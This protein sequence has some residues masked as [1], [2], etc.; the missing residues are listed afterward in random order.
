MT[1]DERKSVLECW[2]NSAH[3]LTIMAQIGGDC[4]TNVCSMARHAGALDA[5]AILCLPDLF[6]RPTTVRQLVDYLQVVSQSAPRTPLFYYHIPSFTGVNLDMEEFLKLG[7]KEI[8]TLA[9]IKYTHTDLEHAVRCLNV[10]SESCNVF[11]GADQIL[12]GAC[13][14]GF[15]SAIATT[16]NIFPSLLQDIMESMVGNMESGDI[17]IARQCQ[18]LLNNR[19][20]DITNFGNISF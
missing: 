4:L 5:G 15:D 19:I 2:V 18:E 17:T 3:R 10:D 11:L 6:F 14:Y 1:V 9:G 13:I 7:R 12:A 20:R 8:S 16:L